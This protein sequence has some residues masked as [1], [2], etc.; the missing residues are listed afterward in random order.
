MIKVLEEE[1]GDIG[2]GSPLGI[3]AGWKILGQPHPTG[4]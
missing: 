1:Q 4:L 2:F 3:K